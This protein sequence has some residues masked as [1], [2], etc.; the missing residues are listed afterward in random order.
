LDI[1]IADGITL[2]AKAA[3]MTMSVCTVVRRSAAPLE[4]SGA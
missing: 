1:Q 3:G 2:S 4:G